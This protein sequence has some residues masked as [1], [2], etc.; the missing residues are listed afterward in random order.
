MTAPNHSA[1][2]KTVS[3]LINE[4]GELR[5][6]VGIDSM[7]EELQQVIQLL[8]ML[9]AR[10]E[11]VAVDSEIADG[12]AGPHEFERVTRVRVTHMQNAVRSYDSIRITLAGMHYACD[13]V[14][15]RD[16]RLARHLAEN[17][18][19]DFDVDPCVADRVS[20]AMTRWRTT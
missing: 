1:I 14:S 12:Q 5:R 2:R 18:G 20:A 15:G 10:L 17:H 6:L 9:D 7:P 8:R 19:A 16:A 3:A 4:I 13:F 11:G